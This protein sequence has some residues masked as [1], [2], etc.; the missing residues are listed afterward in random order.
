MKFL[1]IVFLSSILSFPLFAQKIVEKKGQIWVN[2]TLFLK[3]KSI[4]NKKTLLSFSNNTP[5][6]ILEKVNKEYTKGGMFF[7]CNFTFENKLTAQFSVAAQN[8]NLGLT[9]LFIENN[10]PLNQTDINTFSKSFVKKYPFS[11][12]NKNTMT[13]NQNV[14]YETVNRNK[15]KDFVIATDSILQGG[16]FIGR[17]KSDPI[18]EYDNP[19]LL[20]I[21][22]PNKTSI[23]EIK[24]NQNQL[25]IITTKDHKIHTIEK[26]RSHELINQVIDYLIQN[27]YL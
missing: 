11:I 15:N 25:Y 1:F 17:I 21:M 19:S 24:V 4:S 18:N 14:D 13:N 6:G 16:K 10:L 23:S 27:E 26:K 3:L 22:L 8:F 12:L 7:W 9:K 2:D 20:I 5:I